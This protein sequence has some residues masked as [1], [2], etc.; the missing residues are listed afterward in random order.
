MGFKI[1]C[2]LLS[3]SAFLEFECK[4]AAPVQ[5]LLDG[6]LDGG[7]GHSEALGDAIDGADWVFK[8][9]QGTKAGEEDALD[10]CLADGVVPPSHSHGRLDSLHLASCS[11]L[12]RWLEEAYDLGRGF[13]W[14]PAEVLGGDRLIAHG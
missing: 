11:L 8:G 13:H 14:R 10:L 9:S 6:L 4:L 12:W 3:F 1:G 5:E 7:V 2:K